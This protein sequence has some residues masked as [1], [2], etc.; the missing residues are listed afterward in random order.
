MVPGPGN[1]LRQLMGRKRRSATYSVGEHAERSTADQSQRR[2]FTRRVRSVAFALALRV[3]LAEFDGE[4][5]KQA[6]GATIN[7]EYWASVDDITLAT[8][9]ESAPFVMTK[10]KETLQKRGMEPRS[11]KCT[12]YCL[13]SREIDGIREEMKQF[14]KWTPEGLMILG[15]ASDG[16]YRREI[17]TQ[18]KKDQEPTRGRLQNARIL[19]DKI[20][21]MCEADLT[22]RRL[23]PARKLVHHCLEQCLVILLLRCPA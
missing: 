9:P 7:L 19:A 11:D 4:T 12:A 14:V 1:D 3:A 23:A 2:V 16:E 20:K 18:G 10:L 8:T 6:S 22:C 17:T 13:T 15:T 21:Q 5:R